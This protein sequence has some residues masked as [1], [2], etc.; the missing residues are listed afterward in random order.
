MAVTARA[1]RAKALLGKGC[2]C[3]LITGPCSPALWKAG[4]RLDDCEL[5]GRNSGSQYDKGQGIR[6]RG[7]RTALTTQRSSV[8]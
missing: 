4:R 1:L 3:A 5:A 6:D 2:S 7:G 8:Y